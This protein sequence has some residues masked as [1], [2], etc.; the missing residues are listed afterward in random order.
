VV[1]WFRRDLRLRDNTALLEASRIATD[2]IV[3]VF[4]VSPQEWRAHDEAAVK[5]DFWM[6]NLADLSPRLAK[7][8]IPL[9]VVHAPKAVDVPVELVAL[10][11][12]TGCAVLTMNIEYEVDEARRDEAVRRA[13]EADGR[14]VIACHDRC[15]LPPGSVRTNTGGIYTVFTPFQNQF[16]GVLA[17]TDTTPRGEPKKQKPI[18]VAAT[19]I[20]AEVEGFRSAI[21]PTLWPA[22]E[23]AARKRLKG[24]VDARAADYGET[25][26]FP[27]I[28]GTSAISPYLAAGVVSP[29]E[30]LHAA[31]EADGGVVRA[32]KAHR[33]K[34]TGRGKWISELIWREFYIHLTHLVP[35]VC[36]GRAF[37]PVDRKI[38]W[39]YD[40]ADF[41]RW[42]EG[43]TG[44]PLVDAA[45]RQLN[46]TGWMHNR[47]R[48]VVAMFLTK[49]LLID[50]RWGERYFMH[51]LV[52]GD[53]ASNNG[54]WQWSASTGTDA[55]PYFRVYNPVTQGERYDPEGAFIRRWVPE[56]RSVEGDAVFDPSR[57]PGLV[58][59]RVD[60]PEAMVDHAEARDRVMRVF[61][62]AGDGKPAPEVG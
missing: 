25:R 8:H 61:K 45:M 47:V 39:R 10:A 53:L 50:W 56:L 34:A 51:R 49:D 44:F 41:A 2:G 38:P 21:D 59:G 37:K 43:R 14:E 19:P 42:C 36:M 23:A 11:R 16:V 22:G 46:A 60:Y 29:R 33:G 57:M 6:R 55:A 62:A 9:V 24:F 18:D 40:E 13:F 26:D 3:G 31:A 17:E 58:R 7:L 28:D 5:V 32:G 20:P 52:D 30:C 35:R 4:V 12:R 27:A 15:I 54:G 1:H 48:M